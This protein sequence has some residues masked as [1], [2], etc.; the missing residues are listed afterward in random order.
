MLLTLGVLH[1]AR[2]PGAAFSVPVA[3]HLDDFRHVGGRQLKTLFLQKRDCLR[4]LPR[5]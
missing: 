1:V 2:G 4:L 5:Q 3:L